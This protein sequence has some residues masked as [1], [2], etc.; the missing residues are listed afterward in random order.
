MIFV[1]GGT[2]FLGKHLIPN[3]CRRGFNVRV[4]TRT[5][6]EHPWLDRY[7]NVTVIRGD[8]RDADLMR[9]SVQGCQYVIHA[10]GKFSF[11]GD[12]EDFA[13]TNVNGARNIMLACKEA[14][15]ERVVHVSTVALIGTPS[16]DGIIDEDHPVHPQDA[17]Q[18][19]KWSAEKVVQH[20]HEE[21]GVPAIIL[22]PG[23]FYGPLG[24]YAF[25]RLFFRDALHGW[26]VQLD[27]GN[28]VTFPAYIADVA[29]SICLSLTRGRV[30]EVYN[31]SGDWLT[32]N[33]VFDIIIDEAKL[34]YPKVPM[35]R[36]IVIPFSR[37][38]TAL[39]HITSREPFY[40]IN[41]QSVIFNNWRVVSDKAR[42]ELGFQP[43]DFRMG[44][45][46]TIEW[47]REGMPEHIP[48]MDC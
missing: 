1:T 15:I 17:Y 28:Y 9:Q 42:Q 47:Y 34:W 21:Y 31:I 32:H 33:Q 19:S 36:Y 24:N 37:L 14:Q 44:A 4:L 7:A 23:A 27:G 38:L 25:N 3:L 40:P 39:S 29:E 26:M 2:G 30:G 12:A 16:K 48:E 11:W 13:D 43:T 20:Y 10:G 18:M 8:M 35:S 41:L 46:R 6:D 45:R 5:P 22:R